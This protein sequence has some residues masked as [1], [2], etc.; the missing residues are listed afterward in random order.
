MFARESMGQMENQGEMASA[1]D[2]FQFSNF[3]RDKFDLD[4]AIEAR[5]KNI[6]ITSYKINLVK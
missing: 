2:V 3:T 1:N 4:R 6:G 5:L